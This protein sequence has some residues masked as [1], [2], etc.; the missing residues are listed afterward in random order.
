MVAERMVAEYYMCYGPAAY[1]KCRHQNTVAISR[2]I[3]VHAQ[4][5]IPKAHSSLLPEHQFV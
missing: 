5:V 4:S 2:T 3:G 1:P